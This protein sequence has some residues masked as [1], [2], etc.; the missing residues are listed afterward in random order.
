MGAYD[1]AMKYLFLFVISCT[2][3][4]N[5]CFYNLIFRSD[6]PSFFDKYVKNH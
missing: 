4:K 5:L 2:G 3:L 6:T 1:I